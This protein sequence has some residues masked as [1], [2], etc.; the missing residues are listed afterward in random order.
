M[1]GSRKGMDGKMNP[2]DE[3][4]KRNV[5]NNAIR[6]DPYVGAYMSKRCAPTQKPTNATVGAN[7][8]HTKRVSR[9]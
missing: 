7:H 1:T 4:H 3:L 2:R 9:N 5:L 8:A 6:P